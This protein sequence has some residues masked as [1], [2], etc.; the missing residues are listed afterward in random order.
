M[1]LWKCRALENV[2]NQ[3]Q[4]SHVSHRAW[5]S[6]KARFPHSHRHDYDGLLLLTSKPGSHP[7]GREPKT[8]APSDAARV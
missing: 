2:E 6:H 8:L 1:S 7:D 5:K 4:V 3:K